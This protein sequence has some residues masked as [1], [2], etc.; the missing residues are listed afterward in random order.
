MC[1]AILLWIIWSKWVLLCYIVINYLIGLIKYSDLIRS[2]S[3]VFLK[4]SLFW[5]EMPVFSSL[6]ILWSLL[7]GK[8]N[9][10]L[11]FNFMICGVE[12]EI[13]MAA[14]CNSFLKYLVNWLTEFE[15][16]IVL[17]D[18]YPIFIKEQKIDMR[19][20]GTSIHRNKKMKYI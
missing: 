20:G 1:Y 11:C 14:K 10:F 6:F 5:V 3:V 2:T 15:H 4:P 16:S 9:N 13:Q 12:C 8:C 17:R 18:L 19:S 7:S